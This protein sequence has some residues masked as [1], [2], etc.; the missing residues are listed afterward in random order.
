M[1]APVLGDSPSGLG[2][3]GSASIVSLQQRF[4]M[5]HS[6]CVSAHFLEKAEVKSQQMP[7]VPITQTATE[8]PGFWWVTRALQKG[9][10]GEYARRSSSAGHSQAQRGTAS[11]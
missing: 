2:E 6:S 10:L 7:V 8:L 5:N 11:E 9:P 3:E 1:G 4:T